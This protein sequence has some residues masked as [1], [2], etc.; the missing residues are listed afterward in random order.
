MK[1]GKVVTSSFKE[2][3]S[4]KLELSSLFLYLDSLGTSSEEPVDKDTWST[5]G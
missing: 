4:A 1:S 2:A 5:Y 3:G